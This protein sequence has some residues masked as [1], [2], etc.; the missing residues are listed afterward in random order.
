MGQPDQAA[1]A[2]SPRVTIVD[3]EMNTIPRQAVSKCG[4]T[5]VGRSR[6]SQGEADGI[7]PAG[8]FSE[9][10]SEPRICSGPYS[11]RGGGRA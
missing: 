5:G 6:E 4:G 9:T 11:I 2:D 3:L 10:A 1:S 7:T 8:F